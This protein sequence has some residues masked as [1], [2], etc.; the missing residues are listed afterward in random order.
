MTRNPQR[1]Y[2]FD[3]YCLDVTDRRLT[4]GNDVLRLEPKSFD[5]LRCL[6]ENAGH[7]LRKQDLVDAVWQRSAVTDN[8]LTRCIHQVRGALDDNADQPRF[9]ETVPG[10][11][12]RFIADVAVEESAEAAQ[13]GYRRMASPAVRRSLLAV[14]LI[15]LGLA[16]AWSY[17]FTDRP[18]VERIA[19]LPLQN[20]TGTAEQEYFVHGVHDAL[21]AE[22][23]RIDAIEVISRTSV[24][25]FSDTRLAVPE[26]ARRL[27]VDAVVEGSV[28][29]AGDNL[30]V[31]A[32]LIATNPERHLWAQRY[33]RDVSELFEITT[34]IVAAIAEEIAVE[35]S[36]QQR[37]AG[38]GPLT[39]DNAAYDAYLLG[40][41]LFEQ[42][43][44]AAN[45][46]ALQEFRRATEIDPDFPLPYI[47]LAHALASPAIFGMVAPAEGF[48]E[49]ERLARKALQL[50]E[51][52]AEGY[53]ILGGVAF[54]W[55][56]SIDAAEQNVLRA[57]QLNPSSAHGY[58]LLSEIHSA[59]GR[60]DSALLAVE[61]GREIDPLPPTSQ[62]KPA[63]ILYLARDFDSAIR[64]T[65][66]ALQF[67]PQ[68]WQ[69]HWLL[70]VSLA[71]MEQYDEAVSACAQAVQASHG[72]S[73]ATGALGYVLAMAGQPDRAMAIAA[74]L[75]SRSESAYVGPANIAIVYAALGETD[76][77]ADY[78]EQAISAKDQL[79]P[80]AANAAYFDPVRNDTRLA[81]LL[82]V[83]GMRTEP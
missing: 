46:Q 14:A 56:G 70:C 68:F 77:A 74:E 62:F 10:S 30:T 67:Y 71:G 18:D 60:H 78:L 55:Q 11:G 22:L 36:P 57:L 40:R 15:A 83:P 82:H 34:D 17:L 3:E 4:R 35:L 61:R 79:L 5:V 27:D 43:N 63:L 49:A 48:P 38:I 69:G 80:H 50:D 21:I 51:S 37:E 81:K 6:L 32:Q 45:R 28:L 59:S 33:H 25:G 39:T 75:E 23:S 31:T 8:S 66:E 65:R 76:T 26:I 20:L 41:F 16:F 9:I 54:Y 24:M 42:R 47:G 12:Y 7:L 1:R 29:R 19:V 58:R 52:L 53:L 13:P 73:M 72:L 64:R 2:R 44:P